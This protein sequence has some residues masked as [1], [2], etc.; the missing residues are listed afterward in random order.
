M[1][2]RNMPQDGIPE[3]LAPNGRHRRGERRYELVEGA[4][5]RLPA[6]LGGIHRERGS[7]VEEE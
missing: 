6:D 3:R 7:S 2:N 1:V 5:R 4:L